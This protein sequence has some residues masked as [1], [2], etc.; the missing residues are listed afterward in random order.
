MANKTKPASSQS[1]LLE[2][3][4]TI[5][6]LEQKGFEYAAFRDERQRLLQQE[7]KLKKEIL[8]MMH[9]FNILE[10]KY[11]DIVMKREPGEEQLKVRVKPAS[12]DK[13]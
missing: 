5:P 4:K 11:Q 8:Q 7:V 13:E 1:N 3:Q 10:Y 9:E 6:G 2:H 12:K